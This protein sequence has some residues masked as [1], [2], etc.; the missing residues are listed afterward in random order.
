M[1]DIILEDGREIDFDLKALTLKEYRALFD[2]SQS[3]E[4]EFATL[5]KVS[6]LAADEIG[7]LSLYEWKRFYRCFL[8]KCRQPL[9]DPN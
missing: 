7:E 5:A 9:A 2:V 1:A 4:D 3:D 6:G 8:D